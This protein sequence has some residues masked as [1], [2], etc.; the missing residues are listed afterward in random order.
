[1][2]LDAKRGKIFDMYV[3]EKE[4][5]AS[6]LSLIRKTPQEQDNRHAETCLLV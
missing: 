4:A 6:N 1:M 5:A 2:A 3:S